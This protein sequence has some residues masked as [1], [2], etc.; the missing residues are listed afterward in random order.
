M[1]AHPDRVETRTEEIAAKDKKKQVGTFLS[2]S[3]P[4]S[5]AA[6]A[7][8]RACLFLVF[9]CSVSF[10]LCADCLLYKQKEEKPRKR[11]LW[12]HWT[13][14][15]DSLLEKLNTERESNN[16]GWTM[17]MVC[18]KFN[19]DKEID[20]QKTVAALKSRLKIKSKKNA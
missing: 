3:C 16:K 14:D 10:C 13:K 6:L 2:S 20:E 8:F 11:K 4:C 15:E 7:F 9:I 12:T 5:L 18:S 19:Q 17:N 1:P